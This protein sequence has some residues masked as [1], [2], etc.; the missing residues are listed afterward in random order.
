VPGQ[1]PHLR[2]QAIQAV[3]AFLAGFRVHQPVA[4]LGDDV[5]AVQLPS[6]ALTLLRREPRGHREESTVDGG[7]DL[8][9]R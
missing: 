1:E 7:W 9:V 4:D 3:H 2:Y 8:R 6:L 5:R